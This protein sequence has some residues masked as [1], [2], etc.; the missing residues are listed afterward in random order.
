MC[1]AIK[2]TSPISTIFDFCDL[3]IIG[4]VMIVHAGGGG[5]K[6]FEI[7]ASANDDVVENRTKKRARD[8]DFENEARKAFNHAGGDGGANNTK[9]LTNS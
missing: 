3:R 9:G 6:K 8:E 1:L 2:S 5:W 7:A 4:Y